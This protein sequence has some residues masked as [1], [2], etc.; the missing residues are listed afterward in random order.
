MFYFVSYMAEL[1]GW[2]LDLAYAFPITKTVVYG[3]IW[4]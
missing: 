2:E 4:K 1:N 3:N